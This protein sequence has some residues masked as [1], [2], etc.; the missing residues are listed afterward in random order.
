M[1][2]TGNFDYN[3]TNLT[4]NNILTATGTAAVTNSGVF[5]TATT[6][7]ITANGGFTQDG[8]VARH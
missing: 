4:V 6:G 5:T 3:G 8:G 1:T 2:L 7:D